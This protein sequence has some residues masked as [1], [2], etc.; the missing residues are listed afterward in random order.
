MEANGKNTQA[1]VKK[2]MVVDDDPFCQQIMK[3]MLE[4]MGQIVD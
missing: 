3:M 1:K 4:S 2:V